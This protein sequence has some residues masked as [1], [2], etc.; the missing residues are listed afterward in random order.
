MD[1][2]QGP[3]PARGD[4]GTQVEE[5]FES[6]KVNDEVDEKMGFGKLS[7]GPPREGWL[8]NMR[9]VSFS[10]AYRQRGIPTRAPADFA[11]RS[12]LARWKVSR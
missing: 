6:V 11:Q 10:L 5:R 9:P 3:A 2:N 1:R 12:R 8:V 4:D 7:E